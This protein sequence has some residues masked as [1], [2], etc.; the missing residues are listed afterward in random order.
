MRNYFYIFLFLSL[1]GSFYAMNVKK[2]LKKTEDL[3]LSAQHHKGLTAASLVNQAAYFIAKNYDNKSLEQYYK[4]LPQDCTDKINFFLYRNNDLDQA[5]TDSIK[6]PDLT[7]LTSDLLA[8]GANPNIFYTIPAN[9]SLAK[10]VSTWLQPLLSFAILDDNLR[11]LSTL[12]KHPKIDTEITD[13]YS[14]KPLDFA[15]VLNK[16]LCIKKLIKYG[17]D[18]NNGDNSLQYSPLML[19]CSHDDC[20][21]AIE[22]LLDNGARV[23]YQSQ[24]TGETAL[25]CAASSNNAKLVKLL[26]KHGADVF[27]KS[28]TEETVL[29]IARENENEEMIKLL[30]EAEKRSLE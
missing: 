3:E 9:N 28:W 26:I 25:H 1:P 6:N 12:L 14:Q 2:R 22:V 18:V 13:K 10:T 23:N 19:A 21:D 17:A 30:Q 5:L 15:L 20:L 29:S 27:I 7:H 24:T 8:M 11:G 4:V 16:I